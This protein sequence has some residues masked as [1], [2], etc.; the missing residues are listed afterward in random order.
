MP[1]L[2]RS[3]VDLRLLQLLQVLR[4]AQHRGLL[5]ELQL[6]QRLAHRLQAALDRQA[7]LV[8]APA[9]WR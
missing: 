1:V 9:A 3:Q 4:A 8:A 5:L 6:G 2:K 7:L